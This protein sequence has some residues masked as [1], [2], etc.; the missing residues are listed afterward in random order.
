[1][2]FFFCGIGIMAFAQ[3]K[4]ITGTVTGADD[5]MTIIGATVQIKGTLTGV[6]SDLDGKYS[7]MA[8]EGDILVFRFVG[9]STHEEVVGASNVIDVIMEADYMNLDEVVVVG[10]G[11]Q[12]KSKVTGAISKVEGES[13][14]NTPVPSV[15]LALQGKTAGVFV[16]AVN[17]KVSGATRMRIRGSASVTAD[18]QPLFVVDGI[19]LSS[20]VM[21]YAGADINP[22]TSINV[23]DIQ[24][25]EILKDAA[26]AA[27]YG[28]R[29]ANGVVLIT[30]K[31]GESGATKLNFNFQAGI[32]QATNRREFINAEEYIELF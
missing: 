24:S 1:M 13:L 20:E 10:Y 22:L 30:T 6:T 11:T 3:Q 14:R 4:T 9:M 19:P 27:I 7:I 28:S 5:G 21:N 31:K 23:N 18:N 29:G 26:S 32:S 8:S 2:V 12:I 25:V 16:E 15:E 17:G